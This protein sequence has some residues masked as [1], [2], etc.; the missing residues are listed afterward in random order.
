MVIFIVLGFFY[1]YFTNGYYWELYGYV[2]TLHVC[3]TPLWSWQIF[4]W[5][6][7]Y[8]AM[9]KIKKH[10]TDQSHDILITTL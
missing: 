6:V 10:V 3:L 9:N 5:M 4:M 7:V 1:G 2:I 8:A